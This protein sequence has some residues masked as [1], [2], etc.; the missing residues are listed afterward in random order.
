MFIVSGITWPYAS[1]RIPV[2]WN[3]SGNPTRYAGKFEG[4]F[5]LPLLALAIYLIPLLLPRVS[6]RRFDYE[7]YGSAYQVIR[8]TVIALVAGLNVIAASSARGI[9]IDMRTVFP[10]M[11]GLVMIVVGNYLGKLRRN[12]FVGVRTPWTSRSDESWKKTHNIGGKSFVICGLV[13]VIAGLLQ[14]S[15]VVAF[16]IA[17]L[18]VNGVFLTVYS[19]LIW[20]TDSF[21]DAV[22]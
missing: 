7:R 2:H 22:N 4:L 15:W 14:V 20:R 11:L 12:R 19:Y 17:S 3:I 16:L 8:T 9:S 10:V 5:V 1:E 21:R 6:P 18:V 13:L